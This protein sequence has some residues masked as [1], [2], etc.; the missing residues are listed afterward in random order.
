MIQAWEIW[1]LWDQDRPI[2]G[3]VINLPP[4]EVIPIVIREGTLVI[5]IPR[6]FL[7]KQEQFIKKM[8][9]LEEPL[10]QQVAMQYIKFKNP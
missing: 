2:M 8:G 4:L 9:V 10:L 3:I 6:S 7:V 1:K 5:D